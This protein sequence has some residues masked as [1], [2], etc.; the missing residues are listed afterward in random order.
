MCVWIYIYVVDVKRGK[1]Q[2]GKNELRM[3]SVCWPPG[4]ARGGTFTSTRCG[5]SLEMNTCIGY[6]DHAL[7]L[8]KVSKEGTAGLHGRE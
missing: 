3:I 4:A 6:T 2:M 1:M 8:G 7:I 5:P